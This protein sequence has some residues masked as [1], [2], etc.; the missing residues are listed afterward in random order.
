MR[1]I[2]RDFESSFLRALRSP[3]DSGMGWCFGAIHASER[4]APL[5]AIALYVGG[6]RSWSL[7]PVAVTRF[8]DFIERGLQPAKRF[9][10]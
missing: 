10:R 6:G 2:A 4:A 5:R 9:L 1:V 8:A 3:P 7:Q